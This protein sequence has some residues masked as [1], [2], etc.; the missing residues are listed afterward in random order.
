MDSQYIF[1]LILRFLPTILLIALGF[2]AATDKNTGRQWANLLYQAGSVRP[3]QRDDPK[4]Q[5]GV[6]VPFFV[7]AFGM[8]FLP[9][10]IGPISYYKWVTKKSEPVLNINQGK[11]LKDFDDS[12]IKPEKAAEPTPTPTIP[13]PPAPGEAAPPPPPGAPSSGAPRGN[14]HTTPG[15]IGGLR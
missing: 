10:H 6:K 2:V 14:T 4:I 8:L 9:S 15:S 13:N 5:S 7:L 11:G 1:P 12:A 3:D